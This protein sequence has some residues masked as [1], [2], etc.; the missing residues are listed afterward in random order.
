MQIDFR[1]GFTVYRDRKK[2]PVY[3]CVHSGPALET[4][5]SRDNNSETVASLC[6]MKTGGSFIL[7]NLPRKRVFGI[8]FNRGIP[9]RPEALSNFK[10]FLN[11]SNRKAL[12]EYRKK[13]A[14]V[15]LNNEDYEERLK[16]YNSFWEEVKRNFF[17]VL[18]HT[19]QTRLR[20]VPSL[21]DV[22]S[23]DD[24]LITK[25]EFKE[26][27]NQINSEHSNFFKKIEKEYKSVILLEEE[28][29]ISNVIQTYTK[30]GIEKIDLEFLDKI[31]TGL[32]KIKNLC[33]N[34]TYKSL[35]ANFT[36]RNFLR[37]VKC[38]LQKTGPPKITYEYIFK[39]ERS[40][41]PK[42]ELREILGKNRIILQFEP[43]SFMSSWYPEETSQLITE[44]INKVLERIAK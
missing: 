21:M 12:Y 4:P 6:W 22:A 16:I 27:L 29:A 34:E 11:N 18:I 41:G 14:W 36:P 3:V 2:E 39:G 24:K 43:V 23:F 32:N 13:Y 1:R 28:R 9:P 7:S 25:S 42:R 10:N 8:D 17:V 44:I 20:S 33:G 38:A 5:G 35:R 26:I 31:K 40:F 19:A 30:L 15:A 37:A